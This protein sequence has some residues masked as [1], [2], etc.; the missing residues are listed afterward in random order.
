M[1]TLQTNVHVHKTL[2]TKKHDRIFFQQ[3]SKLQII[4]KIIPL[5]NT[6]IYLLFTSDIRSIV[7][8][9]GSLWN[10]IH[11]NQQTDTLKWT[12]MKYRWRFILTPRISMSVVI[13]KDEV[14]LGAPDV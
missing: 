5:V 13:V 6:T 1:A 11:N 8:T 14:T 2:T 12:T 9:I 3:H 10:E 7:L 4:R